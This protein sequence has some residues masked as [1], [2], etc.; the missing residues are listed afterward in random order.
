MSYVRTGLSSGRSKRVGNAPS[1]SKRED[2]TNI[3][4]TIF[5]YQ[6]GK[7]IWILRTFIKKDEKTPA[8]EIRLAIKRLEEMT[9][10]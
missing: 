2:G 8:H 10:G 4:R 1:S 5:I 9:H 3:A 7:T 6:R